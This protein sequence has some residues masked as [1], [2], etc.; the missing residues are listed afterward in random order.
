MKHVYYVSVLIVR[1][2]GDSHQLLMACRTPEKYM[3]GT[4]QLIT[5]GLEPD[6]IA[7]QGALREM[8]EE[9]GLTPREFYR[10]STLT[11]FYR[12]DNDSLNTSPMFCAVVE[13]AAEVRINAEHSAFE[14]NDLDEAERRLMW[15][16]DRDALRELRSVILG[17]GVAKEHMRIVI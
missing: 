1:Q 16:G 9:T 13:D 7:W 14:W 8:R 15:P 6:E 17:G 12:P 4:W 3:G 10:L 5:G 2:S 11:T